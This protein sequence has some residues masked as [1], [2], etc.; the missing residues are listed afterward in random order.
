M[1]HGVDGGIV[2]AA[3]LVVILWQQHGGVDLDRVPPELSEPLTVDADAFHPLGVAR[4][5]YA[6][7]DVGD[8][9]LK[10]P[11]LAE[12]DTLHIAVKIACS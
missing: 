5:C 2:N 7:D 10:R 8:F 11:A 3:V 1:N 12:V 6:V 4:R 9:D